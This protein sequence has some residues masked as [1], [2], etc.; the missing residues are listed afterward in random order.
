MSRSGRD[1]G[2]QRIVNGVLTAF[3]LPGFDGSSLEVGALFVDRN[4]DV[5]VGTLRQGLYRIHGERVEHYRSSDGLTSDNVFT[6]SEDYEG[7]VW[8]VTVRGIDNF[9]DLRVTTFTPREG[10]MAEEVGSVLASS[11]GALWIGSSDGLSVLRNGTLSVIRT[12]EG[13][14]GLQV[15]SMLEDHAGHLWIG[16]DNE[17]SV[18]ENS[19]FV[20]IRR[21]DGQPL[22]M[23]VGLAEDSRHD[24][25]LELASEP[26]R[27][28]H[29]RDRKV[30]EEIPSPPIPFRAQTVSRFP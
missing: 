13:L 7:D 25:W 1:G 11:D 9:R 18:Y 23:V 19:R 8:V 14:P 5:W 24:L 30:L 28:L 16:A 3:V 10:L 15:T 20:P 2:L 12:R 26:R 4:D 6:I 17:M 27:L 22:G 21:P 29:V